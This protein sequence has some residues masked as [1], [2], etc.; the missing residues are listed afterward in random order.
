MQVSGRRALTG[1][2]TDINLANVNLA[3]MTTQLQS[4]LM[5]EIIRYIPFKQTLRRDERFDYIPF[6]AKQFAA[7]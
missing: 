5:N 7:L 1:V 4:G 2:E 3:K 6:A